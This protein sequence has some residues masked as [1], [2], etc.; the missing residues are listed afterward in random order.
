MNRYETRIVN[1]LLDALKAIKQQ[2]EA[3]AEY[4]K[5][6]EKPKEP[7][8][9]AVV[10][11]EI[12]FPPE[13]T[14]RYYA[15]QGKHYR[16]QRRTFWASVLTLSALAAYTAV[17]FL[18]W[19][20][21]RKAADAAKLSADAAIQAANIANATLKVSE[22]SFQIEQRPYI[23]TD[24]PQFVKPPAADGRV[25]AAN[26]VFRDI[27][28]TPAIKVINQ[29]ALP[30][31]RPSKTSRTK[32]FSFLQTSFASLREKFTGGGKYGPLAR[33]DVAPGAMTFSTTEASTVL[34]VQDIEELK[35][36]SLTIF[37]VGISKYSDAFGGNYETE[38]CY[39]YFGDDPRTWH[40]CDS[41]NVIR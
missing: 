33:R 13:V 37:C 1:S 12:Q 5:G 29:I 20:E 38:F 11:L 31:Y 7:T 41:H 23:V 21:T 36:G 14:Q 19:R 27:G 3:I 24:V 8:Q 10:P 26:V 34:S 22:R 4:A 16:L 32:L 39:F 28:K 9:P 35:M 15:D 6:Q 40:V 30:M 2:I 25:V 17:T 18:Q